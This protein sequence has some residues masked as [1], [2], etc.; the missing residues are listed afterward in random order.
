MPVK[1]RGVTVAAVELPQGRS[2]VRAAS[3]ARTVERGQNPED[4]TGEEMADL[5]RRAASAVR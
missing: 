2:V 5:A 3:A 4:G 1:R